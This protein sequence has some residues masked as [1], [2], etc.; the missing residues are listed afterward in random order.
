[1][2]ADSYIFPYTGNDK[3]LLYFAR[4]SLKDWDFESYQNYFGKLSEKTVASTYIRSITTIEMEPKTPSNV[5]KWINTAKVKL[6][7]QKIGMIW[8]NKKNIMPGTSS[9]LVNYIHSNNNQQPQ[10]QQQPVQHQ[11]PQQQ[12]QQQQESR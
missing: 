10:E 9:S 1:M 4:N 3:F 8:F 2:N 6:I 12:E 5:K 7:Q 11:Q